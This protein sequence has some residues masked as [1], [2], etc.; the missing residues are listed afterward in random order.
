MPTEADIANMALSR[1]GTRATIT[2]LTENSTESRAI[3]IWYATIRDDLL[4]AADWNFSRTYLSL[5]ESGTP[6]DRWAYSY[7]YPSDCLKL[8]GLDLGLP[9]Y[10][11][12]IPPLFEVASNGTDRLVFTNLSPATA[13][14]SQRV[15]DPNRMDPP[16]VTALVIALAAAVALPITQKSDVAVR[17]SALARDA[18][19]TAVA[20]S[21]NEQM[22]ADRF[23]MP[24][25][26][27]IRNS[28]TDVR[29]IDG[30]IYWTP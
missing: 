8:W 9:S 18:F 15:S 16:F 10:M 28:Q 21:A 17:M 24:E 25:S 13:V 26:I 22:T 3:N 5:A 12:T 1:L 29:F 27:N 6:P 30:A 7:A 14:Y 23:R 2:S 19:D 4:R 20:Q 11:Q